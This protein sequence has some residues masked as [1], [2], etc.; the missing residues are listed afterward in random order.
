[1]REIR[2]S[3]W[4]VVCGKSV[5]QLENSGW[6]FNSNNT[7]AYFGPYQTSLNEFFFWKKDPV[8]HL[9]MNLLAKIAND[10]VA[11]F[12]KN[13]H[14]RCLAGSLKGLWNITVTC[15]CSDAPSCYQCNSLTLQNDFTKTS[16]VLGR[17]ISRKNNFYRF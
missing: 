13:L 3:N 9:T 17:V 6:L 4:I 16:K 10:L 2:Q 11:I 1:M 12:A 7:E 15:R 14:H 5:Q 8:K